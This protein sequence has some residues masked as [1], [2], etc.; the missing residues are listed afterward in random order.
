MS[1]RHRLR[2]R[3]GGRAGFAGATVLTRLDRKAG[4]T[5]EVLT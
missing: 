5:V 4:V 2:C 3:Y 1:R